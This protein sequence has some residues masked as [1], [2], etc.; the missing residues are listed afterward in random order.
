MYNFLKQVV[1]SLVDAAQI[2]LSPPAKI[3]NEH[4]A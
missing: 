4:Q 3:S 2:R 1:A